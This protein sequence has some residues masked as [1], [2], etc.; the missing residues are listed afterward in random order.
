MRRP[1][2]VADPCSLLLDSSLNAS[3]YKRWDPLCGPRIPQILNKS[4]KPSGWSGNPPGREEPCWPG[5]GGR[6]LEVRVSL[7]HLSLTLSLTASLVDSLAHSL[8]HSLAALRGRGPGWCCRGGFSLS[9]VR[10]TTVAPTW[11]HQKLGGKPLPL[12]MGGC[13]L[14][15]AL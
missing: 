4:P 5:L 12:L 2:G 3:S 14:G 1:L 9:P 11:I 13:P 8:A 15:E 6:Q 7:P 10:G